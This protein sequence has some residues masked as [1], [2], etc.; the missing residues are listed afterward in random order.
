MFVFFIFEAIL[1]CLIYSKK[2]P[3]DFNNEHYKF[4]LFL[5]VNLILLKV[6]A[7]IALIKF[8]FG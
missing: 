7:I 2:I 1:G 3:Y 6:L 5:G 4:N 8:I